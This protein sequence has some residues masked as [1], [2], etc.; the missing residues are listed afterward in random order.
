MTDLNW[1]GDPIPDPDRFV[2][3]ARD[4]LVEHEEYERRFA[5]FAAKVTDVHGPLGALLREILTQHEQYRRHDLAG[6]TT[7]GETN[8]WSLVVESAMDALD[9]LEGM[10]A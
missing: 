1:Q 3:A 10:G 6:Y 2:S 9:Y 8:R 7:Q 5:R 4:A